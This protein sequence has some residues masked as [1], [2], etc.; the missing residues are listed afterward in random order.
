[1]SKVLT[2]EQIAFYHEQGYLLARG[3]VPPDALAL[4]HTVLEHWMARTIQT[5]VEAGL[6]DHDFGEVDFAHRLVVAWN[7][8]GR[9]HYIRSPRRDL[10]SPEMFAF[11]AHPALIDIAEDLLG[12][13]EVSAHGIFNARPK[14]P[15]QRWTDTPWHQD[16]QYYKDAADLHVVSMWMPLQHVSE[17]NSCLQV[18]P[19]MHR[20]RLFDDY[21]DETGFIGLSPED[22]KNLTGLSMEMDPGDVLCFPQKTPHRALPNQSDAVRWSMDIRYEATPVATESGKKQGFI[23]RSPSNPAAVETWEQW[24][25]KWEAIPA[26]NY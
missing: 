12:T 7:A 24:L 23:A 16:S 9:P 26:G 25:P 10:I 14:L 20:G 1:M 11:L 4:A 19:G 3:V 15:D 17:R 22:R 2:A 21:L 8:A 13:P 5:W 18:V 6:I